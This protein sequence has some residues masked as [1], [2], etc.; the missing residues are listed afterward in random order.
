MAKP[1]R[2]DDIDETFRNVKS[3]GWQLAIVILNDAA[4]AVY[5]YV[6]QLGN[7]KLG[8]VT[9]CASFQAIQRN[10]EKIH[11]C[12]RF[13]ASNNDRFMFFGADVTHTTSSKEKPSIAAIVGSCDLSC[14]RYAVRLCEQYSKKS[15][16]SIKIMKDIDKIIMDLLR[17]FA[18]SCGNT[19]PNQIVFYRDG[20]DDGQFQK[21]LDNEVNKIKSVCR[22]SIPAPVHYAHLAA[23]A[24]KA[25]EFGHSDDE[26]LENEDDG[27]TLE[28]KSLED[29]QT[30]VMILNDD[31]QDTMWFV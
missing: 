10:S 7:Q 8:L 18:H 15:L 23:Y 20:V 21:V 5:N 2:K 1:S 9:Q 11:M 16:C 29:I 31:T 4:P 14:S 27:N 30:N 24:S 13:Q 12:M 19:L 25:Y 28:A 6:K 3:Q 22:V 26:I 17:V